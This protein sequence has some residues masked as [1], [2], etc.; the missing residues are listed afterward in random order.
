MLVER[1]G[2]LQ[3]TDECSGGYV[4]IVVVYQSHLALKIVDVALLLTVR[5]WLLF[6]WNTLQ[7]MN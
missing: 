5:K 1:V 3:P 6:L 2:D 4:F 7:E